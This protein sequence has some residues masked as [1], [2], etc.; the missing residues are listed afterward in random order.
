M[1]EAPLNRT[2][3]ISGI[4]KFDTPPIRD[5]K[6]ETLIE[7]EKLRRTALAPQTPHNQ[8]RRV[9]AELGRFIPIL[10]AGQ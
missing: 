9:A 6:K 3:A 4:V 8:D 5:D 2:F 7:I 1:P 10:R